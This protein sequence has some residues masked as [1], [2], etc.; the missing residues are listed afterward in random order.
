ML[1]HDRIDVS[2]ELMSATPMIH[3]SSLFSIT[4]NFLKQI[5][6]FSQTYV[7]IVNIY[8]KKSRVVMCYNSLC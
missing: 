4:G 3:L 6:G 7:M 5:L 2:K 1:K 8:D